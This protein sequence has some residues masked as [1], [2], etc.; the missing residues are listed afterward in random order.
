MYHYQ[1]HFVLIGMPE[2]VSSA[3]SGL[4]PMEGFTHRVMTCPDFANVPDK[5]EWPLHTIV[6][7]RDDETWTM[8]LLREKF[9][10]KA[11]IVL[12]TDRAEKLDEETLSQIYELWP[13]PL[14]GALM[15]HEIGR[16][17]K[18]I[19]AEKDAWLNEEYLDIVINMLPDMV[20]FKDLPGCHLKQHTAL[21]YILFNKFT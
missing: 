9:G 21:A 10:A 4:V 5:K 7:L 16:L 11:L 14:E 13:C 18:R 17:Q 6:I 2:E 1:L 15:R 20:W 12:C 3:I 19:K 8:E